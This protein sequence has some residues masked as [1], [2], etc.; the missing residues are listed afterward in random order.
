MMLLPDRPPTLWYTAVLQPASPRFPDLVAVLV[1]EVDRFRTSTR[2]L[3]DAVLLGEAQAASWILEGLYQGYLSIPR[4]AFALPL[5]DRFYSGSRPNPVPFPLGA[6]RRIVEAAQS[7]GWMKVHL[8]V[9]EPEG[10]AVTT[11]EAAGDLAKLLSC[12]YLEWIEFAPPP[13]E[14]LILLADQSPERVRRSVQPE[15]GALVAQWQ[16]NLRRINEFLLSRCVY[17]DASNEVILNAGVARVQKSSRP[18]E[19]H[20]GPLSFSQVALRRIFARGRLDLG[21]RF[22]GG[23]WQ[24]VPSEYRR[25]VGIDG[26]LTC[27]ADY[28]GMA[29]NC[30]YALESKDVGLEDPYDIGLSYIAGDDPRRKIVK[31]YV[32]AILNDEKGT[33]KL[34]HDEQRILGLTQKELR[35][36]VATRHATVAHHFHSGVGLKL[37]FY[38]SQIAERVMLRFVGQEKVCLPIHDSFIVRHDQIDQLVQVM[39]EEFRSQFGRGIKVNPDEVIFDE[40]ITIP[41]P[42]H[43]P[44]GLTPAEQADA[45]HHIHWGRVSIASRY[46][47]SWVMQTK[48]REE[49]DAEYER[50]VKC[51]LEIRPFIAEK[52]RNVRFP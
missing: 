12:E 20:V 4:A 16:T 17:L 34:P 5:S 2:G 48:T 47:T 40:R 29:L 50:A 19:H 13:D 24:H 39:G 36:R 26:D 52:T 35:E 46:Y 32:N 15:D 1:D 23:W 42:Q 38:D 27:E 33:Y 28:S 30:L 7:L 51:W 11:A 22:Y 6:V 37:Q 49:I 44:I 3:S 41:D 45:F 9:H 18:G 21:G 10:G 8:G 14:R 43:I 31:K 25:Y